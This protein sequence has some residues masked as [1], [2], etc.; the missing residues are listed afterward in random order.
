MN[1]Q[2]LL[3]SKNAVVIS[4]FIICVVT[5]SIVSKRKCLS[6][7]NPRPRTY[8]Y[9]IEDDHSSDHESLPGEAAT[10]ITM[11]GQ[12]TYIKE[13]PSTTSNAQPVL[14]TNQTTPC[15]NPNL[16]VLGRSLDTCAASEAVKLAE[17]EDLY[18]SIKTTSKNN[19]TRMLTV[20]LTWLQ[21]MNPKQVNYYDI[22]SRQPDKIH[23]LPSPIIYSNSQHEP[24][25]SIK[26]FITVH[27]V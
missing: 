1:H 25:N 26:S 27:T 15:R 19:S 13:T 8:M 2:L 14:P 23:C 20:L 9:T 4:V 16:V 12:R 10:T 5:M 17:E 24:T 6:F 22:V 11:A 3:Q 21:T 18:V 7:V